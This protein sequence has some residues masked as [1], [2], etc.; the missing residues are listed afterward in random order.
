MMADI[1]VSAN[2][3]SA[4]NNASAMNIKVEVMQNGGPIKR[5][6]HRDDITC[7]SEVV[8][9][10]IEDTPA[11][12][13]VGASEYHVGASTV[14]TGKTDMGNKQM[15]QIAAAADAPSAANEIYVSKNSPGQKELD[16]L[17]PS[18]DLWVVDAAKPVKLR[19]EDKG[20]AAH[21]P[22]T[23]PTMLYGVVQ[24]LPNHPALC[25]KRMGTWVKWTYMQYYDEIRKVAKAFIKL[26]LE[27]SHGV[28][29]LGFNAPEWFLSCLGAIFA[30]G[31]ATGIYA[32]NNAEACE[33]VATSCKANIIVVENHQQ[34]QK[35]LKVWDKLPHLKAVIQYTGEVAEKRNNVYS[36][37]ELMKLSSDISDAVLKERLTIQ[38]PNKCCSLIY[39]SGTTGNPKGAMLSQDNITWTSEM[40][41]KM[42]GL[43]YG[44]ESLVSYL[45]L[46]HIAAQ[47]LDIFVPINCGGTVYFAQPDALKGSL[48]NTMREVRPTSFFGV[49]RVWEKMQ[50]K[51]I[52]AGKQAGGLKR[53]MANW[54]K[55]V[56]LKGTNAKQNGSALPFGWCIANTLV[57]KKVHA[58]LGLDRCKNCASGAAPITKD[59]LEF[60]ASL[61]IPL[62]EVYG[63]SECTGPHTISISSCFCLTSCGKEMIGVR[64]KLEKPDEDGNGEVC[65]WGRHVFMGYLDME[66]K[67]REALDEEGWLHSGD[68]GKKDKNGF[69]YIT[70]RIK[71]LIITAGGENIAPVPI[72]D[73]VKEA[74]PVVSNCMLIGDK[75]KFLS[76]LIT[77]KTEMDPDTMKPL[78]N[79]TLEAIEWV[80]S[81][82]GTARTVSEVIQCDSAVL[83]AIQAGIDKANKKGVSRAST[84]QKWSVLPRDFSIPGGEL[85]P[86]MKLRRPIV[87]KMYAK[88]VDAFYDGSD[89]A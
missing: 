45:P 28:G 24:R 31:L 17:W 20:P 46:S 82:G 85:G 57:F 65:F 77:L 27:P 30:G 35:I 3:G 49:P 29:I 59:T 53:K 68:I 79:L 71:E 41:V 56:G 44:L 25:V 39:T 54:A 16:D 21:K 1:E 10:Q 47:M 73:S 40:A 19:M 81:V 5:H 76:M 7:A 48:V 55:T 60:F 38:A 34:L 13:D 86:T 64:T 32:T 72:E 50:E 69:L 74:L 8:Y 80:K 61:D 6:S 26:G 75:K 18:N 12:G 88:T 89:L 43:K 4:G 62:L 14:I 58:A 11:N 70:G 52:A 15:V 36:W 33:Y 67:T 23:I 42:L 51:M 87:L 2:A 84:V 9:T 63:M 37:E 22:V 83:K 66:D 78:D